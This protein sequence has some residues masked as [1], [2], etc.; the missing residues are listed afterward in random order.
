MGVFSLGVKQISFAPPLNSV[1]RPLFIGLQFIFIHTLVKYNHYIR[2]WFLSTQQGASNSI[3]IYF[4]KCFYPKP[5][6]KLLYSFNLYF[7]AR[8]WEM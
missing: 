4:Y 2:I 6:P 7:R 5:L 3:V 8:S 1:V